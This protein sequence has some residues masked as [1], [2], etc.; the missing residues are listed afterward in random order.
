MRALKV[1][2]LEIGRLVSFSELPKEHRKILKKAERVMKKAPY[3]PYSG[4]AVGA[5]VLARNGKVEKKMFEGANVENRVFGISICAERAAITYANTKG[6]G[7]QIVAIAVITRNKGSPTEMIEE[8]APCGECR[9]M[10]MEAARRSGVDIKVIMSTTKKDKIGI[11][12]ISELLPLAF[13]AKLVKKIEKGE[14]NG[15]RTPR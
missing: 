9:E 10:I 11:A 3:D 4:Y 8:S 7:D 1:G 14:R 5:C 13:E 12:Q 2:K 6:Y 15:S